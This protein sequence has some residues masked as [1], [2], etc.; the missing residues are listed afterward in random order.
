MK[1]AELAPAA[2]AGL[3][4]RG[5]LLLDIQ[6]FVAR[7]RSDVP[8][9]AG[10][11][12]LTYGE[13]ELRS[14]DQFADFHI[15]VSLEPGLRRWFKP[16]ARFY[17]DGKPAFLPLP[18]GQAFPMVE[19]GL[20]WCVAAHAHQFLIIHAAVLERDGLALVMPA[21]PGSGKSTLCA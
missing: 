17:Y 21:P 1:V 16:M 7:I 12:A 3:L 18:A 15:E 4:A 9:L 8:S 14:P 6:P 20:N 2:L 13:F 11:I 19:W 5:E 10:N